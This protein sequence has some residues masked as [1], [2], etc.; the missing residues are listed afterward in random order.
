MVWMLLAWQLG[1]NANAD[2]NRFMFDVP[3]NVYQ[4]GIEGLGQPKPVGPGVET[5]FDTSQFYWIESP[6]RVPVLLLPRTQTDAKLVPK[7]KIPEVADWPSP[8]AQKA[9]EGKLAAMLEDITRF[10]TALRA[11]KLD[12]AQG[13]LD[14]MKTIAN[15]E[16]LYFFRASLQFAQGNVEGA[17]GS[18]KRALQSY[19]NSQQGQAF[20]KVLEKGE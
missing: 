18:V 19:P 1:G 12:D 5:T 14:H 16:Y 2:Q 10:Q 3:V 15:I 11:K 6:G 20:L 7:V 8:T 9:L 4:P 17:R 13:A